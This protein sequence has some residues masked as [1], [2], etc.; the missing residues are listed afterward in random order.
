M[1]KSLSEKIMVFGETDLE[2][3]KSVKIDETM[4]P[5]VHAVVEY[6]SGLTFNANG[7]DV[8]TSR[9]NRFIFTYDETNSN[10]HI[11][12]FFLKNYERI[13]D[14]HWIFLIS[15]YHLLEKKVV[16]PEFC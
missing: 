12:K 11:D 6:N 16:T 5:P 7:K 15:G 10:L 9:N 3:I 14:K 1:L 2:S 8:K 4:A 13:V